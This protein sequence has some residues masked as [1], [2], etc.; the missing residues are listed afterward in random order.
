MHCEVFLYIQSLIKG[1]SSVWLRDQRSCF[2]TMS[3]VRKR[4]KL[5]P[6]K[7][8]HASSS[9]GVGPAP[10]SSDDVLLLPPAAPCQAEEGEEEGYL[11]VEE[12][13][14]DS[15]LI[16]TMGNTNMMVFLSSHSTLI[17]YW[18]FKLVLSKN[19]KTFYKYYC[20]FLYFIMLQT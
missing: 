6:A 4:L 20:T 18:L 5:S 17:N 1:C 15:S 13:T 9:S 11:L 19:M 7:Q 12:D 16:I 3:S 8:Q 10:L 2:S 14:T